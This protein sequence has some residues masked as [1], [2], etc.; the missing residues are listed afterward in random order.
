MVRS[1]I[2]N[3]SIK[4]ISTGDYV[5]HCPGD[6][7]DYKQFRSDVIKLFNVDNINNLF[8]RDE[9]NGEDIIYGERAIC[10]LYEDCIDDHDEYMIDDIATFHT[11]L[12]QLTNGRLTIYIKQSKMI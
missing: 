6:M 2:D 1:A 7:L 5:I 12:K 4:K 11:E 10:E 3:N 8:I 9:S